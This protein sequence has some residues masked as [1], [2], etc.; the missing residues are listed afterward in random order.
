MDI[1]EPDRI[2]TVFHT[3]EITEEVMDQL[4]EKYNFQSSKARLSLDKSQ[5]IL[6]GIFEHPKITAQ[7]LTQAEAEALMQT[8]QWAIQEE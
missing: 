7:Y 2:Y 4:N 8:P 6:T 1:D 5:G 3:D